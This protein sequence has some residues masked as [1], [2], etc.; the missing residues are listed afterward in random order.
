VGK[1]ACDYPFPLSGKGFKYHEVASTGSTYTEKIYDACLKVNKNVLKSNA[2]E[3]LLPADIQFALESTY[4]DVLKSTDAIK[5]REMLI[6]NNVDDLNN[7]S[8][9]GG[10]RTC[11]V[12]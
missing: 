7:G 8:V 11:R 10:T 12:E 1:S 6:L 9:N 3:A 2:A 5:Y 4:S